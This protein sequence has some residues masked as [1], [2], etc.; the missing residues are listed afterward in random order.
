ATYTHDLCTAI[1]QQFPR[2]ERLVVPVNDREEGYD[3][4]LEVRFEIAEQD[5]ASY[6]RAADFLNLSNT[7]VVS[8]QH[9]FGIYGGPEGRHI[10]ALV[11]NLNMPVVTTFHTILREPNPEQERIMKELI[12]RSAR[13]VVMTERGKQFLTDIYGAPEEKIDVIPHGIPDM[14]FVDPNFYKDQFGVEGKYVVLTFGLLSPN[15][16]IENVLKALPQVIREFP[17]LVYIILGATHP[18]LVKQEGEAYRLSLQRLA[19]DLGIEKHVIFFNRFVELE[20]LKEF[21]GAAD[22]YITPYLNREQITSGTLSYAFGCGKAV[23]STPYWHAEELLAE[24]RGVLVP[25]NDP[26]AIARELINL[27]KDEPRR[28]AMRKR[29]Y[30][31]GR[32]MVWSNV[33]QQYMDTFRKARL[34]RLEAPIKPHLIKTLEEQRGELPLIRLHHLKRLTDSTGIFQHARYIFPHFAE[35]Y[36][37]DDNARALILTLLLEEAGVT[38]RAV[39]ELAARYAAFLN[40]AFDPQQQRFHNFLSFDRR[41]LDEVGSEDCQ[42]RAIWALGTCVGRSRQR[43]YQTWAARLLEQV[44][45]QAV[46]FTAPRAWAFTLLGIHEYFRQ[47]SGDRLVNQLR[48]ELT[49]RLVELYEKNATEEWPWFEDQ[50][51]YANARLSHA[52]ILS[53]RWMDHPRALEIGLNSLRWLVNI[54]TAEDGHFRPIGCHG[55]YPRGGAPAQFDQQPIEA[56]SMVSACLEAFQ[57]TRDNFWYEQARKAFEWFLGR[58]DLGLPLYD[59]ATGGCRDGLQ[60]DRLNENQGAE[61]T[62]A[63]LMALAEMHLMEQSLNTL[64]EPAG[65]DRR[66]VTSENHANG[67]GS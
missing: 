47:F 17:N 32:E 35:G 2:V 1:G 34:A 44:L 9:E 46:E 61:S 54:Q 38:D 5:I 40:Y 24:D 7:D 20:E 55:F 49:Y 58:N 19:R 26:D 37:T 29:A 53:G 28:H 6:R 36:C 39:E 13:L 65:E 43:A 48:E 33:A 4:P 50:V 10:L 22:V 41:W 60:M 57:A 11:R 25:F 59:P 8:L 31:L 64:E 27:L 21:L 67:S 3:Y 51:T 18:N 66:M 14:P 30:M 45:P 15:K 63:F 16:G 23:I 52:L 56:Q 12:Q 62:L 42:G